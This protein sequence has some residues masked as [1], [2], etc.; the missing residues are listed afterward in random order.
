MNSFKYNRIIIDYRS[1]KVEITEVKIRKVFRD[2]RQLRAILSITLDNEMAIHDIKI[3]T[4]KEGNNLVV[5]PSRKNSAGEYRD[6]VHPVTKE[7]REKMQNVIFPAYEK[8]LEEAE[9]APEE[10]EIT[11]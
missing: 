5:M 9:N 7:F 11:E 10:P 6:I 4:T 3:I 8:A 1:I 2:D